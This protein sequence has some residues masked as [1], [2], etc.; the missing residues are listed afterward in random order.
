MIII[1]RQPAET[2]KWCLQYHIWLTRAEHLW[3]LIICLTQAEHLPYDC[4][5]LLTWWARLLQMSY[6]CICEIFSQN[7]W[8]AR[9]AVVSL[10]TLYCQI[11]FPTMMSQ[12]T[13]TG[14]D[15]IISINNY[16]KR[17]K[18]CVFLIKN[19]KLTTVSSE[20]LLNYSIHIH[21]VHN[22]CWWTKPIT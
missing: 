15:K 10:H 4:T 21:W 17:T 9:F 13:V 2:I 3:W 8:W 19:H 7:W 1:K 12:L 5:S 22:T 11:M 14:P 20:G 16:I 18:N 6:G